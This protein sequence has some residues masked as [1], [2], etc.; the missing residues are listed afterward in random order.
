[1]ANRV[2]RS[3]GGYPARRP[4]LKDWTGLGLDSTYNA[5]AAASA[6]IVGSFTGLSDVTILRIRGLLSIG[7]D[8]V[9]A[10]EE[11]HGALG[12]AIVS[13]EAFTVGI[14][15]VPLPITNDDSDLWMLW[16]PFAHGIQFGT[17]VGFQEPRLSN[18]VVDSKAMR[19]M[20]NDQRAVIVLQNS[21]AAAGLIWH[22]DIRALARTGAGG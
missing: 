20:S 16:Q 5:L 3:R 17:G 21:A 9:A 19:K 12:V 8:Q 10:G 15:A 14:T 2:V 22:L 6:V 13:E 1:V 4:S 7:S 11:V 18:W